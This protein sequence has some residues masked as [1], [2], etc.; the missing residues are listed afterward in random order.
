[1]SS[2]CSVRELKKESYGVE[3]LNAVG[4]VYLSKAKHFLASNQTFMGV[5]GWLHNVQGKY[6]VFSETYVVFIPLLSLSFM[7]KLTWL[8]FTSVSTL[9]SAIELKGVFDQIQAA[10]KAGNLSPEEKRKLEEQAAEK[11]LQALF[12]VRRN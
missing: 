6:H 11:G 8:F 3:L 4:F 12:K 5:G 9:R 10:E 1:M 2:Y 7:K